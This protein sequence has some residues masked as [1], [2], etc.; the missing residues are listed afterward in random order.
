MGKKVLSA[1]GVVVDFD[2][3]QIKNQILKTPKTD[4]IKKR[5]R[6]IDK[7]RRRASRNTVDQLLAQ[8]SQ[9]EAMVREAL[10][11]APAPVKEIK[12]PVKENVPA[13]IDPHAEEV[14]LVPVQPIIKK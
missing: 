12:V 7:K 6:F 9:N 13:P 5:E 3:P 11:K 4:D 14:E 10:A 2:L 1:R 8:Q